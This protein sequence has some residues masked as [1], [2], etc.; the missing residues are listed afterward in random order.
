[1]DYI[2]KNAGKDKERSAECFGEII[3]KYGVPNRMFI[4]TDEALIIMSYGKLKAIPASRMA[5]L[6]KVDR[7]FRDIT[8]TT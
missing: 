3:N 5:H 2:S 7:F 8:S 1:M 4:E 6:K